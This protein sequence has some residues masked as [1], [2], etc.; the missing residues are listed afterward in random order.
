MANDSLDSDL[1][2]GVG[3][4]LAV[5]AVLGALGMVA[6][7][8]SATTDG[9]VHLA[10]VPFALAMTAGVAAVAGIHMFWGE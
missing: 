6:V 4:V 7:D 8:P 5:L 1:G 2:I 10:A 3:A 9:G